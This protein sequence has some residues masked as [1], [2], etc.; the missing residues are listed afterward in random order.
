MSITCAKTSAVAA[1]IETATDD[2]A[3]RFSGPV[4]EWML[5]KQRDIVLDFLRDHPGASVLDVGGGHAQ[6]ALPM[7]EAGYQVTVHGSDET[8]SARIRPYLDSGRMKFICSSMFTLPLPDQSADVV[9]CI[10]LLPHC[11][12]WPALIGELC[13]VARHAVIVD[14]P[15]WRSIN[16]FSGLMFALKKNVE[17]NTRP[18]RLFTHGEVRRAFSPYGFSNHRD[19]G[20]FV[21]PMA[22]HRMMSNV[23]LSS[24]LETVCASLGLTRLF[25]S[26]VL[27]CSRRSLPAPP[28]GRG[29]AGASGREGLKR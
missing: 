15:A 7:M 13:R 26:P 18:F 14:Y 12:E 19:K 17:G 27:T 5:Q 20:Q 4:G 23:R 24:R 8:C 1:D 3:R 2:Y 28:V 11:P 6:I 21:V 25:G 29:E 10:R 16:V 9:T 22:V